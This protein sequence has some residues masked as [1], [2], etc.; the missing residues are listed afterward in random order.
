MSRGPL[1]LVL[2]ALV[3]PAPACSGGGSSTDTPDTTLDVPA[4]P[5][6]LDAIGTDAADT[7]APSDVGGTDAADATDVEV[8]AG[9][10]HD[11]WTVV[12]SSELSAPRAWAYQRGIIHNHSPFSHDGCDSKAWNDDDTPNEDVIA[13]CRLDVRAGMCKSGQDFVFFTDHSAYMAHR[14]FPEVLMYLEGD[15]L[16]ERGGRPVANRVRCDDGRQVIATAGTESGMMPIGIE[17]HPEG[18]IA[19]RKAVYN[20]EGPDAIARLHDLGALVFLHHTEE[21]PP[22]SVDDWPIDGIEIYNT[23][24]NLMDNMSAAIHLYGQMRAHPETIPA[25]ELALL[26]LFQENATDLEHWAR[27]VHKK[28]MV[29]VLATDAHQN[30]FQAPSPDGERLDSFRRMMHWFSNY[31]LVPAPSTGLGAGGDVD[32]AV[33]KQAIAAGRVFGAFHFLG[34]PEGFDFHATAGGQ[35]Y[36]M[37]SK[38]EDPAAT[39]IVKAPRVA[40]LDPAAEKPELKVRLLKAADDATWAVVQEGPGDLQVEVGPG[41]YRAEVRMVPRHLTAWLGTTPEKF[42]NEFVWIYANAIYVAPGW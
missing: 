3:A 10:F 12:P 33:L 35:V 11:P 28:P 30:V 21:W 32:D 36:E 7:P 8:Y 13:A 9:P 16:I 20:A 4:P 18:S 22:E 38:V 39:L 41:V 25:V 1:L 5:D 14:E 19:D 26:G 34:Y 17:H 6:A 42:L 31:L 29:G 15:T 24:R 23:H 37:G 27:V 2:L 40:R